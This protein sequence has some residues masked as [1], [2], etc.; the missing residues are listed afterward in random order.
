MAISPLHSMRKMV[1]VAVHC[2]SFVRE[3]HEWGKVK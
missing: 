3:G 1:N 2:Q